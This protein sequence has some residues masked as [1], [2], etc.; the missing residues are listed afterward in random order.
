M[1]CLASTGRMPR[2]TVLSGLYALPKMRVGG[3]RLH[4]L[5][6][7]L[8]C[9][10]RGGDL[11]DLSH[12]FAWLAASLSSRDQFRRSPMKP[13]S[14][15]RV[16]SLSDV[17]DQP[18]N[19]RRQRAPFPLSCPRTFF[20]WPGRFCPSCHWRP[21]LPLFRYR[22]RRRL[23]RAPACRSRCA[24]RRPCSISVLWALSCPGRTAPGLSAA[25]RATTP[26]ANAALL[27][28]DAVDRGVATGAG[29]AFSSPPSSVLRV[30]A[31]CRSRLRM[32]RADPGRCT[33]P[34]RVLIAV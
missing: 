4:V 18:I 28:R 2:S 17:C 8:H 26:A 12:S 16:A 27:W 9:D 13:S 5:Y 33:A 29:P 21:R 7:A 11:V 15:S 19:S 3:V 22:A 1:P 20:Q 25:M 6:L 31:V 14:H 32:P 34:A 23:C 10:Q 24:A 30:G